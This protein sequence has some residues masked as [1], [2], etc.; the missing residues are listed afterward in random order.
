MSTPAY[1]DGH[2]FIPAEIDDTGLWS[3]PMTVVVC[4]C[5]RI[6]YVFNGVVPDVTCGCTSAGAT[7]GTLRL[8]VN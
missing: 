2:G 7:F 8:A 6:D 5:G 4:D 1:D 3:V